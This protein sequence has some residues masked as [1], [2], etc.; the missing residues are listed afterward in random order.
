MPIGA[1][2]W[3]GIGLLHGVHRQ[4][5]DRAGDGV[6]DRGFDVAGRLHAVLGPKATI[7]K[8]AIIP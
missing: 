7:R 8:A 5:A 3:A 1:P 4:G 2:G 6:E